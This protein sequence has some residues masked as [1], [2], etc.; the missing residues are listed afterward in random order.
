MNDDLQTRLTDINRRIAEQNHRV[1]HALTL[2]AL[3]LV[4][5]AAALTLVLL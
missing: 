4:S 5:S 2:A 1:Q 3:V